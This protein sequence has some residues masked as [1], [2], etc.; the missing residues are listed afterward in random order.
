M[1]YS[2]SGKVAAQLNGAVRR[3]ARDPHIKNRKNKSPA[4]FYALRYPRDQKN[5]AR[6]PAART[7]AYA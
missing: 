2:P 4:T 5:Y 7:H 3:D 6:Q 1:C